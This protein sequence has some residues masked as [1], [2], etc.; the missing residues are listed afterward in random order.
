M[1]D[2]VSISLAIG[3]IVI[4]IL[5][6]IRYSS[7]CRGMVEIQTRAPSEAAGLKC[8]NDFCEK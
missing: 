6:H 7:C 3:G 1:I 5:A 8:K 4:S 2:P